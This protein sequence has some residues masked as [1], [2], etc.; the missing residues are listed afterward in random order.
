MGISNTMENVGS[1]VEGRDRAVPRGN[2]GAGES[3]VRL[4]DLNVF[5]G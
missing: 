4:A 1:E 2:S 3:S 5:E